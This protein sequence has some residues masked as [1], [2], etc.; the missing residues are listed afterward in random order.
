MSTLSSGDIKQPPHPLLTGIAAGLIAGVV[1]GQS[2]R[3]LDRFVSERQKRR[4]RQVRPG[5]AHEVA[6][7]H[8]A[9]KITGRKLKKE[10]EKKAKF[11]FGIAYGIGWGLIYASLRRKFPQVARLAGLPFAIPFFFACDGTIAPLL[12]VSPN[13]RRIPWQPSA[14]EMGNHIAWTAAAEM[15]HRAVAKASK[16]AADQR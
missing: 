8:F 16:Q 9:R 4:D 6:G 2:E 14:K 1:A 5:S 15:V 10:E 13:L 3:L 11:F 12:G 7:P